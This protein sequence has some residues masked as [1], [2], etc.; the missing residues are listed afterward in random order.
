MLIGFIPGSFDPF[1]NGHLELV[2]R[3]SSRCD[4]VIVGIAI[5]PLK[6]LRGRRFNRQV[7]KEAM[8]KVFKR[9]QLNNVTVIVFNNFTLKIALKYNVSIIIR[10]IRNDKDHKYEQRLSK[11]YKK[12]LGLETT[13]FYIPTKNSS[14]KVMEELKKGRDVKKYVPPE[15]YEVIK[16]KNIQNYLTN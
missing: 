6:V 9:E 13:F 16:L 12:I 5:N 10:G 4:K 1:I 3:A 2:K 14:T 8:I 15:I 7:M 11:I